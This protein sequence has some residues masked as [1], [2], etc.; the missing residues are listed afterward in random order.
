[1]STSILFGVLEPDLGTPKPHLDL[2]VGMFG[3]GGVLRI[4]ISGIEEAG[5]SPL[6]LLSSILDFISLCSYSNFSSGNRLV[7]ISSVH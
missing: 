3:F 4:G 2:S 1:M 7:L 6:A 5:R